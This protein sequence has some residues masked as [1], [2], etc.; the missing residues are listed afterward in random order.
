MKAKAEKEGDDG[1]LEYL[2][3]IIGTTKYKQLI[4][5]SLVRIEELNTV[6]QEKSDRFVLVEKDKNLLDEKKVEALKFLELERKLNNFK[7]LKFQCNISHLQ[8]KIEEYQSER[9]EL[10]KQLMKR[11]TQMKQF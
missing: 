1:L 7:S 10:Q 6:C 5:D 4:E 2:E 9:D 3:D 11:K 8:S